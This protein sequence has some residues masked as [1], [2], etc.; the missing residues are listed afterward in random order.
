MGRLGPHRR[1]PPVVVAPQARRV[2]QAAAV[3]AQRA[4]R[5]CA[6]RRPGVAM[7]RRILLLV[8][9][10]TTLVVLAFAIPVALLVRSAVVQRS[11]RSIVDRAQAIASVVGYGSPTTSAISNYLKTLPQTKS[12]SASV[13]L[14]DGTVLGTDASGE[15]TARRRAV[16]PCAARRS[17][18]AVRPPPRQH[19]SDPGLRVRRCADRRRRA[20]VHA[21]R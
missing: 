17:G 8:A 12:R 16:A 21:A 14:P 2:R 5:R 10:V 7:R 18:R 20:L 15:P 6:P 3:P 1:R 19:L 11:E 9:A 13:Y 4:R